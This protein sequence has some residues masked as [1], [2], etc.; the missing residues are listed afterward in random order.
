MKVKV[1][2]TIYDGE[3]VPVMVILSDGDKKNIA[4][5]SPECS[6]YASYPP[7]CSEIGIA[8]WMKEGG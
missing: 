1:G 8:R 7:E 5:M 2:D 3:K 4:N 6:K